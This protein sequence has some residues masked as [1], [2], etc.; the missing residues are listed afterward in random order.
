VATPWQRRRSRGHPAGSDRQRRPSY[1]CSKSGPNLAQTK[2]ARPSVDCCDVDRHHGR[3]GA[4]LRSGGSRRPLDGSPHCPATPTPPPRSLRHERRGDD[5]TNKA[6][7]P[8]RAILLN[9]ISAG[10]RIPL[11]LATGQSPGDTPRRMITQRDARS[12]SQDQ[13]HE[14]GG[15]AHRQS[16][17]GDD[18]FDVPARRP[19]RPQGRPGGSVTRP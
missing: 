8:M 13:Q 2:P 16:D 12:S 10:V 3:L 4:F 9:G 6:K 5:N 7:V 11:G 18:R 19:A 17:V 14:W 1:D 15:V